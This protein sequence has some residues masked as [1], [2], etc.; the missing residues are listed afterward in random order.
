MNRFVLKHLKDLGN[1]VH[2]HIYIHKGS[3]SLS[4]LSQ[5]VLRA[6]STLLYS[7][8]SYHIDSSPIVYVYVYVEGLHDGRLH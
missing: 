3:L 6:L 8:Q 4:S 2:T 5:L 7:T 1:S